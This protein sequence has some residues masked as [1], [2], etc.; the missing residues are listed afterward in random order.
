MEDAGQMPSSDASSSGAMDATMPPRPMDGGMMERPDGGGMNMNMDGGRGMPPQQSYDACMGLSEGDAC[1]FT[2]P[3]RGEVTG[4]C[5]S[6]QGET[7]LFCR[8]PRGGMGG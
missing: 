3:R 7:E 4:T 5:A 1:T 6:R 2:H 8:P